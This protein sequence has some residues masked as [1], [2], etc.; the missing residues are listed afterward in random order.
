[1]IY[2]YQF[3]QQLLSTF[4]PL[5]QPHSRRREEERWTAWRNFDVEVRSTP[6]PQW[7]KAKKQLEDLSCFQDIRLKIRRFDEGRRISFSHYFDP[8]FYGMLLPQH[9]KM[10][11]PKMGAKGRRKRATEEWNSIERKT[12]SHDSLNGEE[13]C[14]MTLTK[15]NSLFMF[16]LRN[17]SACVS[18]GYLKFFELFFC[19]HIVLQ[20]VLASSSLFVASGVNIRAPFTMLLVERTL[21]ECVLFVA[22]RA[23]Q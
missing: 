19:S 13:R 10:P 2:F 9:T 21:A 5:I 11:S 7:P 1:M 16:L 15:W 17:R 4:L 8:N 18:Q 12:F 22:L 6:L 23:E 3:T 20:F 14:E